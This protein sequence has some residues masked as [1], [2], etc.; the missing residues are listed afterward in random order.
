MS[1]KRCLDALLKAQG[2][3]H[4]F[5]QYKVVRELGE[6]G[7]SRVML[8]RHRMTLESFAVKMIPINR[9]CEK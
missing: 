7:S 9:I 1:Q 2:F 3:Q 8:T 4:Q 6:G 5:D